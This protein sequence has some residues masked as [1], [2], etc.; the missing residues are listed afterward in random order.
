L[1]TC[2]KKEPMWA[3][4]TSSPSTA[5]KTMGSSPPV[6]GS[7][8]TSVCVCVCARARERVRTCVRTVSHL[9]LATPGR[10]PGSAGGTGYGAAACGSGE[11]RRGVFGRPAHGQLRA[12]AASARALPRGAGGRVRWQEAGDPAG[13]AAATRRCR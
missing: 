4:S 5:L 11:C 3:I 7:T 8:V 12:M 13:A 2:P 10:L 6:P 9:P 1:T